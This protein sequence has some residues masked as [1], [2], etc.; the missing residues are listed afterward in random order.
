MM[1]AQIDM[2]EIPCLAIWQI[3]H[4]NNCLS[5]LWHCHVWIMLRKLIF[6]DIVGALVFKPLAALYYHDYRLQPFQSGILE[7]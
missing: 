6:D 5:S 4:Y 3:A 2:Y 7:E 1:M